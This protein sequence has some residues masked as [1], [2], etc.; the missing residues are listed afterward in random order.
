M[1]T[2]SLVSERVRADPWRLYPTENSQMEA[3]TLGANHPVW[4]LSTDAVVEKANLLAF[5]LWGAIDPVTRRL[6]EDKILGQHVFSI[7]LSNLNRIPLNQNGQFS[8]K[9]MSVLKKTDPE[10]TSDFVR[11]VLERSDL[12]SIYHAVDR[13]PAKEWFYP[14]RILHP[15]PTSGAAVLNFDVSVYRVVDEHQEQ[16]GLLVAYRSADSDTRRS[17]D[18]QAELLR[19]RYGPGAYVKAC[20]RGDISEPIRLPRIIEVSGV[21][22]VNVGRAQIECPYCGGVAS[23]QPATRYVDPP[24]DRNVSILVHARAYTC[25]ACGVDFY[26]PEIDDRIDARVQQAISELG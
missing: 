21:D 15:A 6:S 13:E 14:L 1:P 22:E 18:E 23:Y 3:Q 25:K 19:K 9:K 2:A 12:R 16:V 10:G 4:F 11:Y 20:R 26:R 5:W 17:L 24:G 8:K 7:I